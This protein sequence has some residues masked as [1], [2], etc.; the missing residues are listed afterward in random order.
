[1]LSENVNV[2]E[3]LS[4]L[5]FAHERVKRLER[6]RMAAIQDQKSCFYQVAKKLTP[7]YE[8]I[9]ESGYDFGNP[10]IKLLEQEGPLI[11]YDASQDVIFF[12]DFKAGDVKS[13][14]LESLKI[15][16]YNPDSL[17]VEYGF[18]TA[19]EG[20]HDPLKRIGKVEGFYEDDIQ[21]RRDL[22]KRYNI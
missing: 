10:N 4:Q 20:L 12:Y 14:D 17:F 21:E 3:K 2:S 22:I 1:M 7:I 16:E 8:Y 5:S 18:E 13:R 19:M 9:K 11:G 15:S 6:E